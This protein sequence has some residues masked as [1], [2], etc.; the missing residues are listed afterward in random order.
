MRQLELKDA[1]RMMAALNDKDVT[2]NM[3][4]GLHTF[5]LQE[6]E[7]FIINE[8]N[9]PNTKNFAI[10]DDEDNWLGTVS[11]K[12]IHNSEAEYAI[13]TAREAHGKG[14]AQKATKE[15]LQYAFNELKLKKVFLFVS[16]SN[17]RANK[18]YQKFGWR[19]DRLEKDGLEL[20]N[21]LYDVNWYYLTSE[22][23]TIYE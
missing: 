7:D 16:A 10:V 20:N 17:V 21:T 5:T 6:C 1:S 9:N 18:F 22:D 15:I 4:V 14:Y 19:F 12:D 2:S 8:K 13:L 11:L 23:K 3:R